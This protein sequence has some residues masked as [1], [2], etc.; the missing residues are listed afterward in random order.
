MYQPS[1][2]YN[3]SPAVEYI[4]GRIL[5]SPARFV[6]KAHCARMH[7]NKK[8]PQI[9]PKTAI[10]FGILA[11][12][13]A[14]VFIRYAQEEASSLVIATYRIGIASVILAPLALFRYRNT[15][16]N[17]TRKELGLGLLSGLFLALHFATWITSLEYTSVASSVV[18][19]STTP[20]WVALLSPITI[21]EPIS[22]KIVVGLVVATFGGTIVGISD[23]CSLSGLTISC[24]PLSE[25]IQGEAFFGD[26]L[27]LA[28]ALMGAGYLLI[29]RKLRS[30]LSLIPY[31]SLVY[32]FAAVI[33]LGLSLGSGQQLAGYSPQFYV[34]V[35][36]LG[37][38]PQLLGHSTFNWALGYLP[39]VFVS[40]TLLGEPIGSSILA[41]VLLNEAPTLLMVFGAILILVGIYSASQKQGK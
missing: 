7:P 32:G 21:R 33:L 18:L 2:D 31:I 25:F 20:L 22:R 27:A 40:I 26:L 36:S 6:K 1:I 16:K 10:V 29:G 37:V 23:S 30:N 15:I 39:A 35:I 19:V 38:V 12:S 17:L 3:Y 5:A 14:S 24:P 34:W 41:L 8:Q 28:G 9:P 4:I 11:V 13:T